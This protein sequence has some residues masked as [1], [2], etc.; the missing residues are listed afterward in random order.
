[1][2]HSTEDIQP[3]VDLA[4]KVCGTMGNMTLSKHALYNVSV[5]T[6]EFG[7][8]WYGD[9]EKNDVVTIINTISAA[10]NQKVYVLDE[11]F[12]FDSPILT[13]TN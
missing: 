11:Q 7:K 13:S 2:F 3:A 10:I 4:V 6:R 9:L 1:M 8:L 5:A 12:N